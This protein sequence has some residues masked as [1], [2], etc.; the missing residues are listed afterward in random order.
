MSI[1][2]GGGRRPRS[3]GAALALVLALLLVP[4]AAFAQSASSIIVEGNRRVEADT[5]RSYFK[6]SPDGKLDAAATDRA[7]KALYASGL[8]QDVK[9]SHRGDKLVVSVAEAP[10]IDKIRFEGNKLLKD[11]QLTAEIQSKPRAP[12]SRAAVQADVAR[13]TEIY[14]RSGRFNA[15][16]EPKI[17]ERP[18]ERV[19]LIFEIQEKEKTTV[20]AIVFVGN[21]TFGD[22][23]LRQEIK[24]DK[25]GLLSFLKG[26]D[27][28]DPDRIEADRDLLQRFYQKNGFADAR[29]VSG[30]AQYDPAQ[31]GFVVTF[32]IDE[33][34]RYRLGKVEVRS[35]IAA[36]DAA[37][38]ARM[39]R[40]KAGDYYNAEAVEKS[41][42]EM[43]IAVAKR[44][45]PFAA[46]RPRAERK[47]DARVIDLVFSLDDATRTYVERIQIRGNSRT[48]DYVIRREFD[49][50]EG[51][52]Y[53]KA[54]IARAERRLKNLGYFK[55][56]K[57]GTEPGSAPDRVV[58]NVDVEEQQTGNFTV[59]GGYSTADGFV[60][61]VGV[62]ESNLFGRGLFG[63]TSVAYGQHTRAITA[64]LT[65]PFFFGNH[66]SLGADIFAK[67]TT[68]SSYQSFGSEVYGGAL[69]FGAPLTENL[70]SELRY[71]LYNQRITLD[72]ALT[73][74]S[75][76]N[77]P[78][79]CYAN[80]EASL[81]TKQ[82]AAAGPAWVSTVG[83]GITYN[84]LDN[85][86]HPTQGLRADFRQDL[87][88]VGGDVNFWKTTED[89]RYYHP[90]VGDVVGMLRGQS[91]YVTP[92]G[93]QQ[94]RM[95]DSFFGGP[96]L[97]RG[98]AP[99]GFG[100]RDLTAGTTMDNV[101]GSRYWAT[102]AEM[103]APIGFLPP[104][105]R[106]KW[107]VFAD[108]GSVWGFRS[109]GTPALSS[110]L[111]TGTSNVASKSVVRSS[112]GA[113]LVWDSPAGPLRIDYAYPTSKASYDVTQR[114]RFSAGP[115]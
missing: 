79:G 93:G 76:S 64:N 33:G 95:Q 23:R 25:T 60:A 29:I 15:K 48:R 67:Q 5:V 83:Y 70:G 84:T 44:G 31:K 71:S 19:D 102:T 109:G 4:S 58:L 52:A 62:S 72:P 42:E 46:V 26:N 113:G 56:V 18:S 57:I 115:Y 112:V 54:L 34:P 96:Q 27:V 74:C 38:F 106:L 7:I 105:F 51:D 69:R 55:T 49:L 114:F 43:T 35:Q 94:L 90:I 81:P 99:N 10:L 100:P 47:S 21:R 24:T 9:L 14:Q 8:F 107:A 6:V 91:G 66:G 97:V 80:Q 30:T 65:D 78:P 86:R 2:R 77:P 87:A 11:Q 63:K 36:V 59:A 68:T 12:L 110:S 89:V 61:E 104:D 3:V 13:I 50:A 22:N 53:N 40:V 85:I 92:W 39:P 101:G 32:T 73:D 111:A 103:Q 98:F 108:A 82:A 45:Y 1:P 75:P 88:G 17:I 37:P 16:I 28:Y 20:R 41:V